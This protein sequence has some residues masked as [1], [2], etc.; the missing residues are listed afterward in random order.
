MYLHATVDTLAMKQQQSRSLEETSRYKIKFDNDFLPA[1][2]ATQMNHSAKVAA[3]SDQ[4]GSRTMESQG[5]YTATRIELNKKGAIGFAAFAAAL[6]CAL[7]IRFSRYHHHRFRALFY[8]AASMPLLVTVYKTWGLFFGGHLDLDDPRVREQECARLASPTFVFTDYLHRLEGCKIVIREGKL[9]R[10][11]HLGIEDI[12]H[13]SLLARRL[14][15]RDLEF[16]NEAYYLVNELGLAYRAGEAKHL[17]NLSQLE[18]V[19]LVSR[20]SVDRI[21]DHQVAAANQEQSDVRYQRHAVTGVALG[22]AHSSDRT[23]EQVLLTGGAILADS[24]FSSREA[25]LERQKSAARM[26]AELLAA[27]VTAIRDETRLEIDSAARELTCDV[28]DHFQQVF[29]PHRKRSDAVRPPPFVIVTESPQF[30][31]S[32]PPFDA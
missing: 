7:G 6:G 32:A 27:P 1:F 19:Y 10:T 25:E 12:A 26:Q 5:T 3:F 31:P 4:I 22:A 18:R 24:Y 14:D 2:N 20:S 28:N 8:I 9:V 13:Y 30:P 21:C 29:D 15:E 17:S 11:R 16:E 23:S